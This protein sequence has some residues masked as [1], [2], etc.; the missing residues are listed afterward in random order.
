MELW[1]KVLSDSLG[2]SIDFLEENKKNKDFI[3]TIKELAEK[4]DIDALVI[5]NKGSL[6]INKKRN[7]L[8]TDINKYYKKYKLDK[9]FN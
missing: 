4:N 3:N 6:F 8:L 9:T 7:P 5:T 1:K 2:K